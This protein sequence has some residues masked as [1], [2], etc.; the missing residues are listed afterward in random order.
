MKW[1]YSKFILTS[2]GWHL[3][4]NLISIFCQ[5]F[6]SSKICEILSHQRRI[7][8]KKHGCPNLHFYYLFYPSLFFKFWFSFDSYTRFYWFFICLWI[9]WNSITQNSFCVSWTTFRDVEFFRD[10]FFKFIFSISHRAKQNLYYA[11]NPRVILLLI[12]T[13]FWKTKRVEK[14]KINKPVWPLAAEQQQQCY[15]LGNV[16]FGCPRERVS[17]PAAVYSH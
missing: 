6:A 11:L 13:H 1:P 16:L 3:G 9:A 7:R 8:K 12:F 10:F 15:W 5:Y 14:N 2:V 17:L 4:L